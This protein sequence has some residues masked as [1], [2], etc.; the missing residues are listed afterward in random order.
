MTVHYGPIDEYRVPTVTHDLKCI[1]TALGKMIAVVDPIT[2]HYDR[3]R[4]WLETVADVKMT[5]SHFLNDNKIFLDIM[6]HQDGQM[7]LEYT[8]EL[9]YAALSMIAEN[10]QIT[11]MSPE[12]E[13]FLMAH[14]SC[15]R[16]LKTMVLQK[17]MI[18]ELKGI[19]PGG[20]K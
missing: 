11:I 19:L 8:I 16:D 10:E 3:L 17:I 1:D 12:G 7:A 2:E 15:T 14:V 5:P 6:V 13:L 4:K 18:D 20:R 9:G